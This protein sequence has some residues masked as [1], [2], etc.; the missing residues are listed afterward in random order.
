MILLLLDFLFLF[1]FGKCYCFFLILFASKTIKIY[2]FLFMGL[3]FDFIYR[4]FFLFTMILLILYF[5]FKFL[6]KRK[7]S[8]F[9]YIKNCILAFLM[10]HLIAIIFIRNIIN[11]SFLESFLFYLIAVL[12]CYKNRCF[13]IE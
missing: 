9:S 4:K 7:Q 12:I 6:L 13:S 1:C 3:V 11:L 5:V 10:F 2:P 8:N